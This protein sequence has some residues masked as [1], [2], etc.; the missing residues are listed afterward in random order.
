MTQNLLTIQEIVNGCKQH[1]AVAQKALLKRYADLLYGVSLRYVKDEHLAQ[2]VVQDTFIKVFKVI[3]N[4]DEQKGSIEAWMR[5]IAIR[6]ALKYLNKKGIRLSVIEDNMH[7]IVPL[8][9]EAVLQLENDDLLEVIKTLPEGYRQ[10]FNLY[11]IEGYSHK[12]IAQMMQI[13]EVSSRS[14]LSR[15]KEI[16]RKKLINLKPYQGWAQVN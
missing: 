4:Y 15:A 10:V 11:V 14:N 7:E 3:D 12:E 1:N 13:K 9:P 5:K 16:L 8:E 2:E 6:F